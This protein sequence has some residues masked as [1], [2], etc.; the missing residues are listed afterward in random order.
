LN[1]IVIHDPLDPRLAPY[2]SLKGKELEKDG[3]FIAEGEKVVSCMVD[4]SCPI[5]SCLASAII[6]ELTHGVIKVK[7]ILL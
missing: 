7:Y 6:F 5:A 4:S 2:R 1:H 3:I